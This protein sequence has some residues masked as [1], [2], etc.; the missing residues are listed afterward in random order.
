MWGPGSRSSKQQNLAALFWLMES[1][2]I[3]V[4]RVSLHRGPK[5]PLSKAGR[6]NPGFHWRSQDWEMP[7][8]LYSHGEL[9][10]CV[11]QPERAERA[12][13]ADRSWRTE[14]S[15]GSRHGDEFAVCPA[16]FQSVIQGFLSLLFPFLLKHKCTSFAT[17]YF[18]YATWFYFL[19]RGC[20]K[21]IVSSLR[22]EYK[23]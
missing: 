8:F 23:P 4:S 1:P 2:Y 11:N 16:G 21:E 20:S 5:R 10:L 18:N 19:Q 13:T 15:F 14:E 9:L 12:N 3:C 6:V 17:V 7:V 22:R